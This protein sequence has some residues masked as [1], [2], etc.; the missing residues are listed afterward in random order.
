MLVNIETTAR[1]VNHP[2]ET[3]L[4]V[5]TR[6]YM[7]DDALEKELLGYSYLFRSCWEYLR[8]AEGITARRDFSPKALKELR[9]ELTLH[10]PE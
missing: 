8:K 9:R 3:Y 4:S 2:D 6:P 1:G 5:N 10:C 7:P